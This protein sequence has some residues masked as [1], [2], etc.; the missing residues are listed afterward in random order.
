MLGVPRA[1]LVRVKQMSD[2]M[3]LF[4]GSS[5][6]SPEK[7]DTAETATREM[8]AFFRELI[9]DRRNL[10][11][12]DLLS[13]LVH[14]RDGDDRL[15]DD[16][17]IA[18]CI[19]L[20]FAGHE[21]TTNR[22]PLVYAEPDRVDIRRNEVAH[23]AFGWGIHICLGF[24]LARTEGQVAFPALLSHFKSI[25]PATAS[26]TWINSLVFRGMHSLPVR[27]QRAR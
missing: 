17:L 27:V 26:T 1:E 13:E 22:D 6:T 24:P 9:V 20:L 14:L 7:Y 23:L 16:E 2:D 8:A 10:A 4:I 25:E 11:R 3:A 12:M 18:M 5:R 19:L 21:T 15:S